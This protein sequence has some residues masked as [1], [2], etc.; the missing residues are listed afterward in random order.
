MKAKTPARILIAAALFAATAWAGP[1]LICHPIDI[2]AAKSLPWRQTTDWNGAEKSYDVSRLTADTLALL[3][4]G[5]PLPL[6]RE[7]LRRAAIYAAR[8][9]RLADELAMRLLARTL[10][11]EAAGKPEPAAWFDAGYFVETVHQAG[12]I[13]EH[14][15]SPRERTTWT[16]RGGAAE[17][18]GYAWVRKAIRLGGKDMNES[19]AALASYRKPSGTE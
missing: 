7:T 3:V 19:L 9:P 14:M 15:L 16:I 12:F 1:P 6:R 5:A 11:S 13:Y 2:G 10:D 18:D 8:Q 17:I 4:P